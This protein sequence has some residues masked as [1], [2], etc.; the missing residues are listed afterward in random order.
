MTENWEMWKQ[1]GG[2][3]FSCLR[4]FQQDLDPAL[5]SVGLDEAPALSGRR[6]TL[7]S[8]VSIR[9]PQHWSLNRAQ[10]FGTRGL[11]PGLVL[12]EP[13]GPALLI[14]PGFPA[15]FAA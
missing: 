7:V 1:I 4:D 12:P 8:W 10:L 5:L 11:N 6:R 3:S 14:L 13:S 9:A 2:P 15:A